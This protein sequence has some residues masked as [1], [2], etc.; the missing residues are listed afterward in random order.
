[1]FSESSSW[2]IRANPQ[3][4]RFCVV[5]TSD[6]STTKSYIFS[7]G[8]GGALCELSWGSTF[9]P[10]VNLTTVC[11]PPPTGLPSHAEYDAHSLPRSSMHSSLSIAQVSRFVFHAMLRRCIGTKHLYMVGQ[12]YSTLVT[13]KQWKARFPFRHPSSFFFARRYVQFRQLIK[14]CGVRAV[15]FWA[16][17]EGETGGRLGSAW[18]C[19]VRWA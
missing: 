1:M 6:A 3:F 11:A 5:I 8:T 12:I 2:P 10:R 4:L 13:K 7:F 9:Q 17:F 16:E 14:V 15:C 19:G 18:E